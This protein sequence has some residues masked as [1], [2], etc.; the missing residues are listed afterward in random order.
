MGTAT[1]VTVSFQWGNTAAYGNETQAQIMTGPA[2]FSGNLTGLN[3]ITTYHF[4]AKA[5]GNG[6]SYGNDTAFTTSPMPPTVIANAAGSIT[7]SSATLNGNLTAMGTATSVTV[8]FEWGNTTSYGNTTPAQIK[9]VPGAFSGNITGL[10]PNTTYHFRAKAIGN[11]TSYS[12]D[13]TFTTSTV[14]PSVVT[15]A[16]GNLT[17]ISATLNGN[18]TSVGTATTVTVSFQWGNT[19]SYGNETSTQIRA[20]P[21]A[22]SGNITGLNP[23]TTYHFRTKATGNGT[24][25]GNDTTF[26]TS[27]MPPTVTTNAA[28]SIT[29][30]SATLNGTLTAKGTATSVTVSFQ[31]GNT[32][33]YGNETPGQI[34][35]VPGAF[36]GNITGLQAGTTYHFRAKAIGNGTSYGNDT[37]F[38]TQVTQVTGITREVNGDILPGVSITLDGTGAVVSDQNGQ[39]QIIATATG[40]Y[41]VTAHK[42]GFRDRTQIVNIAGL[43]EGSAVTCNF[44]GNLGLIPN[45]PDIWYALDC[46]NRWLYPPNPETGLDIWTALDVVNA[47]LYPIQ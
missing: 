17:A 42:D 12:N 13:T 4:R 18:L 28:G 32:T 36:S 15:N 3:P 9:T 43:G 21:G 10:N 7:T 20:A 39:F 2:A 24:S 46:V 1:S 8:S 5:I 22:F 44:Q 38:T 33:D 26:T 16:A 27:P 14:P 11:G 47:W 6:T 25:Y 30:S 37:I 34:K 31:W 41:A 35:T 45:A 19:I 23:I 29:T 40:D